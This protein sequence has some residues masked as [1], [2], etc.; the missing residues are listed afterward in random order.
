[1]AQITPDKTGTYS[2]RLTVSDGVSSVSDEVRLFAVPAAPVALFEV[3]IERSPVR[4]GERASFLATARYV[5]ENTKETEL[6]FEAESEGVELRVERLSDDSFRVDGMLNKTPGTKTAQ[7][8]LYQQ[9]A[10]QTRG[11]REAR[12]ALWNRLAEVELALEE[13]RDPDR[14][15]ELLKEKERIVH[16]REQ[17]RQALEKFRA[18]IGEPAVREF[19]VLP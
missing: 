6:D 11:I 9:N 14:R 19:E 18:Q 4:V 5:P 12:K 10:R 1:M 16:D 15:L 8:R 7:F 3:D 13:E 2:F 17:L